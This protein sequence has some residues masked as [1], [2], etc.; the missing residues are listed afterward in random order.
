M[1]CADGSTEGGV[2]DRAFAL[3]DAEGAEGWLEHLRASGYVVIRSVLEPDR[4]ESAKGWLQEDMGRV[5]EQGGGLTGDLVH[6]RGAWVVRA[7]PN[8]RRS[9]AQ[10]WKTDELI[11]SMDVVLARRATTKASTEGLH[12]DQN[13]FAK[14]FLECVQ[15]MVP[16]LPVTPATGGLEVVPGS[17]LDAAK[18]RQRECHPGFARPLRRGEPP[19]DW[20]VVGTNQVGYPQERFGRPG[21]KLAED[22]QREARLLLAQPGDLILWDSRT[23]HGGRVPDPAAAAAAGPGGEYARLSCTVCMTPRAFADPRTILALRRSGSFSVVPREDMDD[24]ILR[25]R[26]RDYGLNK[27]HNHCP[28]EDGSGAGTLS[29][30]GRIPQAVLDADMNFLLDG[31]CSAAEPAASGP[32]KEKRVTAWEAFNRVVAESILV[33]DCCAECTPLGTLPGGAALDPELPPAEAACNAAEWVNE[34]F[35]PENPS[36]AVLLDDGGEKNV[37]GDEVA[38]WLLAEGGCTEVWRV[39]RD[40][41]VRRYSFLF[42]LK[43]MFEYPQE[44]AEGTLFLGSMLATATKVLENLQ[45]THVVTVVERPIAQPGRC[46]HLWCCVEDSTGADLTPVMK[47]ALPF[48]EGA[49]GGGGR[50]LVHCEQGRSRSASV[51]IAHLMRTRGLD[52]DD[53]LALVRG[54]RPIARP[55]ESFMEQLRRHEWDMP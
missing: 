3:E 39:A 50:V 6:S 41:F 12:L 36:F 33:L 53:A 11:V 54:Q 21:K 37:R 48:I 24:S 9:F 10:I 47:L 30:S 28:F 1:M 19:S 13:P 38:R 31:R 14:R 34:N 42:G 40:T 29:S 44:I 18:Q 15:G 8:I 22:L 26:R 7:S 55:N 2:V 43:D 27:A 25:A 32:T 51:V 45:I 16:L 49:I 35:G 20:C 4:I 5:P 17:H 23:V 52:L 46:E